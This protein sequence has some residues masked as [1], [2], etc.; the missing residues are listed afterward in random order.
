MRSA[1]AGPA[2]SRDFPYSYPL[3]GVG[4]T[5]E[6]LQIIPTD[7]VIFQQPLAT[8]GRIAVFIQ[9][10]VC[11]STLSWHLPWGRHLG[12]NFLLVAAE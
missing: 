11:I 8:G 7:L 3:F 4:L 12:S 6:E 2:M 9:R 10:F 1:N 5:T